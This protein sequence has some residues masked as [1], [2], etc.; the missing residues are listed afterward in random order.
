MQEAQNANINLMDV[1]KQVKQQVEQLS[2]DMEEQR[3]ELEQHVKQLQDEFENEKQVSQPVCLHLLVF[4]LFLVVAP[5]SMFLL[6]LLHGKAQQTSVEFQSVVEQLKSQMKQAEAEYQTKLD[7]CNKQMQQI[8]TERQALAD[9]V[10]QMEETIKKVSSKHVL[11]FFY[12]FPETQSCFSTC[13]VR[14]ECRTKGRQS[15]IGY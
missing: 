6:Q 7:E 4:S 12:Q 14:T 2:V 13:A 10:A 9:K 11:F 3:A 1:E 15:T 5:N 8:G